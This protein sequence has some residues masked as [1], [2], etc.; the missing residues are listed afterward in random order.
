MAFEI[1]ILEFPSNLGLIEPSPGKEPGVKKLPG[2]LRQHGFYAL[3]SPV[4]VRSLVPPNYTMLIDEESGVRN[5]AAISQ[6]AL[7]QAEILKTTIRDKL[8]ALVIGGDCSILVGNAIALKQSG[9][10]GLFFLDGHTD[11][12]WPELSQTH[13]A[14][15]MDLAIVTGHGHDKLV[16]ILNLGPYLNE[17]NVFC[18]GNREY[19]EKYIEP[20]KNSKINYFDLDRLRNYGIENCVNDFLE[21][22]IN[23]K[24]DGFWIHFDADALNDDLMP[25][26]D[27]REP[28]GLDYE[29]LSLILKKLLENELCVG[30]EIT[31]LDPDLDPGAVY[32]KEFVYRVGKIIAGIRK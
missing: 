8:F 25:A 26:V 9:N 12:I 17:E 11:Y 6:Y 18:A 19:D 4:R 3:I 15:G 27:S 24:L 7:Q 20:I 32:T 22:V 28:G 30:L 10:Y 31:I 14:A 23:K 1:E 2:W 16:D 5:A 21:M 13:G 29:E